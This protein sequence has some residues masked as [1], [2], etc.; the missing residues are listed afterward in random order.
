MADNTSTFVLK[1]KS[2]GLDQ[3]QKQ[4]QVV[5]DNF[6]TAQKAASGTASSR[7]IAS[8]AA[9]QPTGMAGA[10]AGVSGGEVVDYNRAKGAAG[11]AGGT[12]RDFADQ[13]R[14]LGGL[15]RLYATFA[16]NIFAATAAFGAL[17]RAMDTTNMIQGLDQLGAASGR[18]LGTLSKDLALAS[19]GAI[20]LRDSME[21]TAKASAAGLTNK[22]I[23]QIGEAAKKASLALGVS[24]PDALSRLSR[25][26][27]KIEPELLDELGL[28]VKIDDA[29]QGYARSLG[30]TAS[31][32]T[33]FERR[34]AFANAVLDQA[35]QKFSNVN[36]DVN[37]YNKLLASLQNVLQSGL[38]V[39][40]K[41]LGPVAKL[42]AESPT[43]LAA[44]IAAIGVTLLKQVIP[45]V[46][47]WRQGLR[48]AADEAAE[49]AERIKRSFGDEFQSRLE[50]RFKIPDL[51]RS[52]QETE[53]QIDKITK[54]TTGAAT[55]I[56][57][58]LSRS[59]VA[60]SDVADQKTIN[61]TQK[62]IDTRKEYIQT[63]VKGSKQLSEAAVQGYKE[64]VSWLD[65]KLQRMQR[66]ADLNRLS[67]ERARKRQDLDEAFRKAQM[68]ADKPPGRFDPE[69]IAAREYENA[70]K[71]RDR[72]AAV[73]TAADNA[74]ILGVRQSW[75]LLNQEIAEKGIT[76]ISR[77]TT[78]ASG[79]LAA[80]GA[81]IMGVVGA[82]GQVGM[83]VAT[84]AAAWEVISSFASNNQK[85]AEE[86]ARG[87]DRLNESAK[88]VNSVL[89]DLEKK[90]PLAK[91]SVEAVNAR[92]T[93]LNELTT[94]LSDQITKI[95]RQVETAN[96]FDI[97]VDTAKANIGLGL[98][99]QSAKETSFAVT[100]AFKVMAEGPQKSD[101]I[102]KF[103]EAFKVDPTDQEALRKLLVESPEKFMMLAPQVA[104]LMKQIGVET[105]N[106]AS[107]GKE[108]VS[109]FD[110]AEKT[111]KDFVTSSLPTDPVAKFGAELVGI[112]TKLDASL[113]DPQNRLAA[114]VEVSKSAAKQALLGTVGQEFAKDSQQ[115]QRAAAE[116]AVYNQ[117]IEK[118]TIRQKELIK[119]AGDTSRSGGRAARED[120][121]LETTTAVVEAMKTAREAA[122]GVVNKAG[123]NLEKGVKYASETGGKYIEA[124]ISAAFAKAAITVSNAFAQRL[125]DTEAG[126]ARRAELEKQSNNLQIAQ[127]KSQKE[128]LSLQSSV[129]DVI[130][131]NTLA[132]ELNT[133]AQKESGGKTLSEEDQK[134]R[135]SLEKQRSD[136]ESGRVESPQ[137]KLLDLAKRNIDA[138][139]AQIAA[140]NKAIDIKAQ[141]ETAARRLKVSNDIL[142]IETD[143]LNTQKQFFDIETKG[144]PYL[145][146]QQISRKKELDDQILINKQAQEYSAIQKEIDRN[147][148]TLSDKRSTDKDRQAAVKSL[149][150]QG[151]EAVRV[152]EKQTEERKKAEQSYYQF[153]IEN[154]QKRVEFIAQQEV[155]LNQI[156]QDTVNIR[157]DTAS[158]LSE[159]ELAT[160]DQSGKYTDQYIASLKYQAEVAK[161]T[162]EAK[163]KEATLTTQYKIRQ[164]ELYRQ[165]ATQLAL[166]G[167]QGNAASAA[168]AQELTALQAKYGAEVAGIRSITQA[169][170]DQAGAINKAKK[171][172]D[173]FNSSL[174]A[175]KEF[176]SVFTSIGTAVSG[177]VT[178]LY[179]SKKAQDQYNRS[180]EDLTKKISTEKDEKKKIEL[181]EELGDLNRK[182]AKDEISDNARIVGSTKNLFK[183]K[184]AAYKIL[185]TTEK[186]LHIAR[187]IM[188]AK[189]TASSVAKTGVS[190]IESGKR[191]FAS[192]LEAITA[193]FAAKP[194][195][196]GIIAGTAM[197]ATIGALLGKA[198]G[199]G[200]K[201]PPAGFTSEEQ[202]KVQGTGQTYRDGKLVTR[203]GGVLGD[204][205]ARA[206]SVSK[207]LELVSKNT[208][209][210]LEY[211]NK[212]VDALKAIE[213]NTRG[214]TQAM[215]RSIGPQAQGS[216]AGSIPTGEM[217]GN[218]LGG[219]AL[220]AAAGA[221]LGFGAATYIGIGGAIA[222]GGAL[223]GLAA[224][225]AGALGGMLLPGIG[226]LLAKP[227]GK[228][229]GS[230][231]GGKTT[232]TIEAFGITVNGVLDDVING[233]KGVI[234][235]W[236]NVKTVRKGGWFR[237]DKTTYST[238]TQEATD[239]IK[240]IVGNLFMG[241]RDALTSAGE[242]LGKD[243]K[244]TLANY[245]IKDFK[246]N[247]KDLKPEELAQA[248]QGEIS[249]AFNKMAMDIF[250]EF[251]Q[252]AQP[253]EE[254]GETIIR[255]AR[256]VQ[257]FDL[258]MTSISKSTESM[259]KM[260]KVE[261]SN[262]LVEMAGGIEQ[263]VE[264][265][266]FYA[267]NFLT[268]AER[269]APVQTAV[270][271]ELGRLS[272]EYEN[273]EL[274][275]INTR[276]Q[277]KSV[278]DA[279]DLTVP[280]GRELYNSL[281]N[282]APAFAEVYKEA[283]KLTELSISDFVSRIN[284][285]RVKALDLISKISG[286]E[287]DAIAVVTLQRQL[288]LAELDKYPDAQK[289]ILIANQ[290][291]LYAL[292]DELSAK[293]KLVKR[294]DLLKTTIDNISKAVDTLANYKKTLLAGDL[295]NLLPVDKYQQAKT[296]F[297]DLLTTINKTPTTE[298]E[299]AAQLEAINKLPG[300]SD[301]LL[302]A[303]RV[304]NASSG[305]YSSDLESVTRALDAT[306]G[307]LTGQKT[308][309]EKQLDA[310]KAQGISLESIAESSATTAALI[311]N[312]LKA[313][314]NTN[315]LRPATVISTDVP[316]DV[317]SALNKLAD[318]FKLFRGD[319]TN[320]LN[321]PGNSVTSA[322]TGQGG[323]K[324]ALTGTTNSVAAEI[325]TSRTASNNQT[326]AVVEAV[327]TSGGSVAETVA[328]AVVDAA[329]QTN[330]ENRT[331]VIIGKYNLIE[332]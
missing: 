318:E 269:L 23:L 130:A 227:I 284:E 239:P 28:F 223:G 122:V 253:F 144:L 98:L 37:P 196:L 294:R 125:G 214:L 273:S 286:K 203:E 43:A 131:K 127:L 282:L 135:A 235:E 111:L 226:L 117:E 65:K 278:V 207:S 268:E 141:D 262:A 22:Q 319:V 280:A 181:T 56:P 299:K 21:A 217:R 112:G 55:A 245:L 45:V 183:E 265:S 2:E 91:I 148:R 63:G 88:F 244:D 254:A 272:A 83:V 199:G 41:V 274:A 62:M 129:Q 257:V 219:N 190:V 192:G 170:L 18:N 107:K 325:K 24:M 315:T 281:M 258:A 134:R 8:S 147:L 87:F 213:K 231:F 79:G 137:Q 58:S 277:F 229:L 323:V 197:I 32:L 67:E 94:N 188:D 86:A 164:D 250:P 275:S 308:D 276:K 327:V 158:K 233:T 300:I 224:G 202:N 16:A 174:N 259:S 310:I 304:V 312:F 109:A 296:Q 68:V 241:V 162:E 39:V 152:T 106:T 84:V 60:Q 247:S 145:D 46:G 232:Q 82:L 119:S 90:D 255:L 15:V 330:Y 124:G 201:A 220:G 293:D 271:T 31:S 140:T 150:E 179:E 305:V 205:T 175:L 99:K 44:V 160:A 236:A 85:E 120:K 105:A 103:K 7:R 240:D 306:S 251:E 210:N 186:A 159:I 100:Q 40:N 279:I 270:I 243:V 113:K 95:T 198:F 295:S 168:A 328:D 71:K 139:I 9:A 209:S 230:I 13:A 59:S 194:W 321:G 206:S 302:Q 180:R 104:T 149:Q 171:E 307:I 218:Y 20:S 324:D 184:T 248:I 61:A 256:Q 288:E 29:T 48:A 267:D 246:I 34:Q 228:L 12:A 163:R 332:R 189:E 211:S 121:E 329:S 154:E 4:S 102:Q 266:N 33:D 320:A 221:G 264:K 169:Q 215:L 195:P 285:T 64:E 176:E 69:T 49:T 116:L 92:A 191:A 25:G 298:A 36:I 204:P 6:E 50:T 200:S 316:V 97:L 238:M 187:L 165:I 317:K 66:E 292:E 75:A 14:G 260:M 172:Q 234:E 110:T 208:F 101:A 193:A 133:L 1:V 225:M 252:F 314:A 54:Q 222:G 30:K 81:R 326:A 313:Q 35:N 212:M 263:F 114:I 126:I 118:R 143:R 93:A 173:G 3:V 96:W 115:I 78:L 17:S 237:S 157:Q 322:L 77:F 19:D 108:L 27:S 331:R 74:R 76:G 161:I 290:K 52:L 297:E 185:A 72:L 167:G 146:S 70:L 291:Y 155:K 311:D 47:Q 153:L 138:Q 38:E 261:V 5:R 289:Q 309:A 178:A 166:T 51:Q 182:R 242:V 301:A 142:S 10:S 303:S 249:I 283:E 156:A 73:S 80:A 177:L 151:Q 89:S 287:S 132:V 57:A 128:M 216:L 42:L 53:K 26:I 123:E 11:S 136:I